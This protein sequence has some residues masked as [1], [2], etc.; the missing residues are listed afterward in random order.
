MIHK[1]EQFGLELRIRNRGIQYFV[2]FS[3]TPSVDPSRIIPTPFFWRFPKLYQLLD[4]GKFI[5]RKRDRQMRQR[6][7]ESRVEIT[8]WW[9]KSYCCTVTKSQK[10]KNASDKFF[11]DRR[12]VDKPMSLIYENMK[13]HQAMQRF[14]KHQ[15]WCNVS[16][17]MLY[18]LK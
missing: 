3:T 2:T 13:P 18:R 11:R 14:T 16:F 6:M 1:T 10:G 17:V 4:P 7:F 9:T 5:V 15:S 8:C 12:L